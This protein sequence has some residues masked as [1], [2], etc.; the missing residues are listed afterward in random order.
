MKKRISRLNSQTKGIIPMHY[1]I[2]FVIILCSCCF[3]FKIDSIAKYSF[4]DYTG[5]SAVSLVKTFDNNLAM[6]IQKWEYQVILKMD[7]NG[8]ILWA[9]TMRN[10]AQPFKFIQSPDSGFVVTG[11]TWDFLLNQD[12]FPVRVDC[13]FVSK[14]DSHGDSLWFKRYVV[15]DAYGMDVIARK[16]GGYAVC[17]IITGYGDLNDGFILE[18][19]ENGDSTGILRDY[20]CWFNS[21]DTA[22]NGDYVVTGRKFYSSGNTFFAATLGGSYGD[23]WYRSVEGNSYFNWG[24]R[25][26]TTRLGQYLVIGGYQTST[27]DRKDISFAKL[28]REGNILFKKRYG[29]TAW[30]EGIDVLEI[31]DSLY[32]IVG[33]TNSFPFKGQDAW[34]LLTNGAGDTLASLVTGTSEDEN[35]AGLCKWNDSTFFIAGTSL[36]KPFIQ[37]I[38]LNNE[39]AVEKAFPGKTK[40]LNLSVSPNPF[41]P[42][43]RISFSIKAE[44]MA[45]LDVFNPSGV[46]IASVLNGNFSSGTHTVVFNGKDLASGAYIL[47]LKTG[48]GT[49][50]KAIFLCR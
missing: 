25:V 44:G 19:D 41:N 45:S 34:V 48:H 21:I 24:N 49:I 50:Q 42:V 12:S 17:G 2:V 18:L 35:V 47:S 27:T 11:R 26:L 14:F 28:D 16:N 8:N 10:D 33:E 31:N 15:E 1:K 38:L 29:G 36:N 13:A 6:M 37:K 43:T 30:D 5:G 32:V 9:D 7:F 46:K 20:D 40:K 22:S 4:P 23:Y 3:P 39:I